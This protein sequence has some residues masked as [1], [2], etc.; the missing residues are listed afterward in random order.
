MLFSSCLPSIR[1][2]VIQPE[3]VEVVLESRLT[4]NESVVDVISRPGVTQ[5]F[6]LKES[7]GP[8]A[9]LILFAGGHGNLNINNYGELQWGRG[10]FLVRSSDHFVTNGFSVAIVDAPSDRKPRGMLHGFR[11]SGTHAIDIAAVIRFLKMKADIPV[12]M[13][14]TSRGTISAVN[15]SVRIGRNGVSGLVLTSSLTRPNKSGVYMF[16]M[17]LSDISVPTLVTH[18]RDDGCPLTPYHDAPLII[19]RLSNAPVTEL[20]SFKGGYQP[21]SKPCD[22]LSQH[23]YYGIESNVV[24]TISAWIR[25]EIQ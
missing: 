8:V 21:K 15:C 25:K 22:A 23:G 16:K 6:I 4:D 1:E 12:W 7:P 19:E 11:A 5:R 17:P 3:N 13:V 24:D 2:S 10:N 9:F 18:H 14:G 20:I